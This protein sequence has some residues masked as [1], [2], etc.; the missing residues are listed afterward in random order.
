MCACMIM[1][2]FDIQTTS[3][4]HCK[5]V[6]LAMHLHAYEISEYY[7]DITTVH[8]AMGIVQCLTC[9]V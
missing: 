1:Y 6:I 3:I 7:N 9:L 5:R 8:Q 4:V 2:S